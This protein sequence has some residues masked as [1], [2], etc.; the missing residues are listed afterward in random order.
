MLL[1]KEPPPV[2]LVVFVASATVGLVD[3][4]QQTPLAV[5]PVIQLPVI[6]P[7]DEADVVVIADITVV[8]IVGKTVAVV[9]VS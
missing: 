8:V 1:A 6:L 9:N 5:T 2:P 4:L 3:V 7:P